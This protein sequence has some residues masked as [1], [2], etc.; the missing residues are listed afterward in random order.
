MVRR[1][2]NVKGIA[3]GAAVALAAVGILTFYVWYQTESVK[4]GLDITKSDARI[5]EL[6]K[7]IEALK[8]RR[9]ALLDPGRVEA[10][11][12]EKLGL[13]DPPNGD[14]VFRTPDRPR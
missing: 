3:L 6:E 12:R 14:I 1:K 10:I 7:T 13:T 4:L 11:A 2:W 8:L 5:L 9:A